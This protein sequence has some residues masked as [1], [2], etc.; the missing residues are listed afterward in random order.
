[1]ERGERTRKSVWVC[2]VLAYARVRLRKR[3]EEA[4]DDRKGLTKEEREL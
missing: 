1:M 2:T 4:I 3:D